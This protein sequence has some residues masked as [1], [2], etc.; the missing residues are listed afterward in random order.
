M[1]ELE[2]TTLC[3]AIVRAHA[4]FGQS[5]QGQTLPK[6]PFFGH[7]LQEQ[8][9]PFILGHIHG[10]IQV[11]LESTEEKKN[12]NNLMFLE[13]ASVFFLFCFPSQLGPKKMA[14]VASS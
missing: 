8:K 10:A 9:V 3:A 5:G 14:L 6:G 7:E 12:K 2:I 1:W 11:L 4:C 13:K